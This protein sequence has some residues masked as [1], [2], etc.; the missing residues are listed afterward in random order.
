[1][2]SHSARSSAEELPGPDPQIGLPMPIHG[3][4]LHRAKVMLSLRFP[5]FAP[6]VPEAAML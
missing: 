2:S 1:M 5:C 4:P 6:I 3:V